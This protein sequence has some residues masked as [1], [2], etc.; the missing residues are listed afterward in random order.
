VVGETPPGQPSSGNACSTAVV[1]SAGAEET[2]SKKEATDLNAPDI[3]EPCTIKRQ[4]R[5]NAEME[6]FHD[7]IMGIVEEQHPMTVRQVYYQAEVKGLIAKKETEYAKVMRAVLYLRRSGRMPYSWIEDLTRWM[8]KPTT[9]NGI[10]EILNAAAS[11]YRKAVWATLDRRVELWVEKDAL[12]GIVSGVAGQFDV[13]VLPAR[14]YSSE[15]F[16]YEAAAAITPDWDYG[17]K[18]F[19]YHFG[20]FDPSGMNA[21]TT[22]LNTLLRHAP[23]EAFQF[24]R[25]AVFPAQIAI[26]D[27]PTR[28]TKKQDP[29]YKWFSEHWPEGKEVSCEL[30]A[31]PPDILR[32]LVRD[33]IERH[34]PEGWLDSIRFAE[35]EERRHLERMIGFINDRP[36]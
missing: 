18:T 12:A 7:A 28:P 5:T 13:P 34:L 26:W 10:D 8:R 36:R 24:E 2:V 35:Q 17:R 11:S 4:R 29:R 16:A 33:I 25:I 6:S 20:D 14:G 23:S 19:V 27:L 3:Y 15:S 22:L 32:R 30:D 21:S 1:R 9:W 31:I